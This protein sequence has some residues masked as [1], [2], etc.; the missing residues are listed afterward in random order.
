MHYKQKMLIHLDYFIVEFP[1]VSMVSNE[2]RDN[3]GMDV[4]FL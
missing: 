4:I 2:F 1:D 3:I